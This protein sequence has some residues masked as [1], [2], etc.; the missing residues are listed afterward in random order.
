MRWLWRRQ[1]QSAPSLAQSLDALQTEVR[2]LGKQS[3]RT[4]ARWESLSAKMD[5][6]GARME[7]TMVQ[8][9]SDL[10]A[11]LPKQSSD[12][13]QERERYAGAL[14]E[15]MDTIERAHATVA[16]ATV[17]GPT[18]TEPGLRD[19]R[20]LCLDV[21]GRIAAS[22]L[23]TLQGVGIHPLPGEGSAFDPRVHRAVA[24]VIAPAQS[25]RVA[26]VARRGYTLDGQML[27]IAEVVVG[28]ETDDTDNVSE[29][30]TVENDG[31]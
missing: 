20:L 7:Q 16:Q 3:L 27:R 23:R 4:D 11:A 28:T 22:V 29:D 6:L 25:G 18:G 10:A 5:A 8:L 9:R 2:R 30:G 13:Q 12:A 15:V 26:L 17:D 14:L 21:L 24:R 19:Q 31:G 1:G